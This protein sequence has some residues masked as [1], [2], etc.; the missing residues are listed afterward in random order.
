MGGASSDWDALLVYFLISGSTTFGS[1][2][3][4]GCPVTHNPPTS[5]TFFVW[6]GIV[7]LLSMETFL[8][9]I[10]LRSPFSSNGVSA[11][12]RFSI[13]FFLCTGHFPSL[14]LVTAGIFVFSE[15]QWRTISLVFSQVVAVS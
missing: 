11:G 4:G 6:K 5:L 10:L 8:T 13:F 3:R 9:M 15:G 1:A 12:S 14:I 2:G 7:F